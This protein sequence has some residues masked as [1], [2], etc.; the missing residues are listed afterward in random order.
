LIRIGF[1]IAF[2]FIFSNAT[3][4]TLRSFALPNAIQIGEPFELVFEL[5]L[6][7]EKDSIVFVPKKLVFPGKIADGPTDIAAGGLNYELEI[8]SDFTD[9]IVNKNGVFTWVGTYHL[10]AWDSAWVIIPQE[11]I[12][13]NDSTFYFNPVLIEVT[14]P[15][16][17]PSK[18]IYDIH[19]EFSV[20][21]DETL[22]S[23]WYWWLLL[24]IPLIGLLIFYIFRKNKGQ[25]KAPVQISLRDRIIGEINALEESQLYKEDLKE[26]YF[27]LSI[28]VRRFLG[29]QFQLRLMERTTSEISLLLRSHKITPDTI[30]VIEMLLTQ[31]D[32]VKFAKSQPPISEV[33]R[34]TNQA[35]QIVDEVAS[36]DFNLSEE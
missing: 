14:S 19:E 21:D 30:E 22:F 28:I 26:Y 32:M 29:E 13:V 7:S 24:A 3:A 6:T 20:L 27:E 1:H 4:Q 2:W 17:D 11:R 10:T 35:R 9:T 23:K 12:L 16:A 18:D 8:L 31:S 36:L 33:F 25:V 34:I 5:A 15:I